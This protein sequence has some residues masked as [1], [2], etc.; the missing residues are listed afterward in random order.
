MQL[1]EMFTQV[2]GNDV[3][4]EIVA[5]DGSKSGPRDAS[6]RVEVRSPL[7]LSYFVSAPGELGLARAYVAG[8]LDVVG[9]LFTALSVLP[10]VK[11]TEIP[12]RLRAQ[13]ASRMLAAR[14]WWPVGA[15]PQEARPHHRHR[16]HRRHTRLRDSA[17]IS[18][19][20]D[21]SNEFYANVLGPSMAYTCAVYPSADADLEL[22]QFTKHDLVAR[23]LGL[24]PG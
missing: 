14:L 23:K 8:Q 3:P 9:D 10:E 19:H 24:A 15:P 2:I 22:A 7:A 4:V 5:Y 16:H 13:A 1:A 21:V 6:V 18:H 11:F 20:Y 12:P 17:A